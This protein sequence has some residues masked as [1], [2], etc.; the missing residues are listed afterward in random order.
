M[1]RSCAKTGASPWGGPRTQSYRDHPGGCRERYACHARADLALAESKV[2][3]VVLAVVVDL[4][5]DVF[6]IYCFSAF[7]RNSRLRK[8]KEKNSS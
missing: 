7:D 1:G 2:T 5:V 3:K 4:N 6:E 8:L